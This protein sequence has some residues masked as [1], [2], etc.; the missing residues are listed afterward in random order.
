MNL[1]DQIEFL[2]NVIVFFVVEEI[3]TDL[4]NI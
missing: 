4:A 2:N 1:F 3:S